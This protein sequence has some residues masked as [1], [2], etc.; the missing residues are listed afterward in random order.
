MAKDVNPTNLSMGKA[1]GAMTNVLLLGAGG[2][3]KATSCGN[4]LTS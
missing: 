4:K 1:V 2:V 3:L